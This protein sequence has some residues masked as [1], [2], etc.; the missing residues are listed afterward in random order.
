MAGPTNQ[1]HRST[2]APSRS[3]ILA[4]S[5]Y[6]AD[7]PLRHKHS[8]S[9][10]SE[11]R[12][13]IF[14]VEDRGHSAL[15]TQE[16]IDS[17]DGVV[18]GDQIDRLAAST[19]KAVRPLS[20][21][22]T[23]QDQRAT[24]T[25]DSK[26]RSS[27]TPEK[28]MDVEEIADLIRRK[29]VTSAMFEKDFLPHDELKILI[30]RRDVTSLL[31]KAFPLRKHRN[32]PYL[33]EQIMGK[34]NDSETREK[35]GPLRRRIF[36][37]LIMM[38]KIVLIEDFIGDNVEDSDL[39]LGVRRVERPRHVLEFYNRDAKPL[40]KLNTW[41]SKNKEDFA[42][43]QESFCAPFFELPGDRVCF[44]QLERGAILPYLVHRQTYVGGYSSVTQV[45]IHG[46]HY[47]HGKRQQVSILNGQTPINADSVYQAQRGA[48]KYFAVKELHPN[49]EAAYRREVELFEKIG[50]GRN[51]RS[52]DHLI[53]LQLT[54]RHGDRYF[55]VFPWADGNLQK[56]WKKNTGVFNPSR[57]ND[58]KWFFTQCRGLLRALRKIHHFSSMSGPGNNIPDLGDLNSILGQKD[59]GRHGD[60]KPENILWFEKHDGNDNYLVIADFGLTSFNT[61]HSRS[62]VANDA[63]TGCSGTHR[64]PEMDLKSEISPR[65]DIWSLGCVYLE[66][67]SWFLLG[68]AETHH[69]FTGHRLNEER[70]QGKR[71]PEDTFY[72]VYQRHTG[73]E[74]V[75]DAKVKDSVVKWIDKLHSQ[76][77][78]TE[79][80]HVFLDLILFKMLVTK[81]SD[82]W[83]CEQVSTEVN[84]LFQ[85][86]VDSTLCATTGVL[87]ARN[88]QRF[89][90]SDTAPPTVRFHS[91]SRICCS[92][93][94]DL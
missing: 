79:P 68:Y 84:S 91:R 27:N 51:G 50:V 34:S 8:E 53:Q 59:Y 48:G 49:N 85:K 20:V 40:S 1:I 25:R 26:A 14:T 23:S 2:D 78:C 19:S 47:S 15:I 61:A 44:Y 32:I 73:T 72:I 66:F 87:G 81:P 80:L 77:H 43:R 64:P 13:S 17:D 46:S 30:N 52:P 41:T 56:F 5:F 58:T 6:K 12:V 35:Q 21:R 4:D 7:I 83:T 82:R 57:S 36:A 65:Y 54:Y 38:E 92:V 62:K 9:V 16:A 75:P 89:L 11:S 39:P 29:S 60:I 88:P 74:R 69:T 67:V 33:V 76:K 63:V 70:Q 45:E 37:T 22:G 93:S 90:S 94:N 31:R 3:G 24:T 10:Y 71:A 18:A 86:C 42:H 55:L 28:P